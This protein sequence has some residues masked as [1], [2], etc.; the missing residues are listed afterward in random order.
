[1]SRDHH[2]GVCDKCGKSFQYY[3]VHNGFN[4]SA[5][6]Y[7]DSDSYVTILDG[8]KAPE[9]TGLKLHGPIGPDIEAL[10]TPSPLGGTFKS[11][12]SPKCPHCLSPLDPVLAAEYIERDA[13]GTQKGWRWDRCWNGIYCII[14]DDLV[15]RDN[16]K[17]NKSVESTP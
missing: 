8:W 4:D 16:W 12:E 7:S 10:L 17:P 6:A 11:G 9:N 13:P 3:L 5:Y 1:M 15:V 14:I 2:T